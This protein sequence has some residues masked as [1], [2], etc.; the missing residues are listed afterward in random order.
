V[1][2]DSVTNFDALVAKPPKTLGTASPTDITATC[3]S[4]TTTVGGG[5]NC[6]T[7]GWKGS[8][9]FPVGTA[10]S[11]TSNLDATGWRGNCGSGPV[12]V[13]AICCPLGTP[14]IARYY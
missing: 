10:D 8:Y 13:Y 7:G 2:T 9:S 3:P 4:G 5:R 11:T 6:L 14:A 12:R 1:Y